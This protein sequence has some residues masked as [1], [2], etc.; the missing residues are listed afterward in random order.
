MSKMRIKKGDTVAVI[1][2]EDSPNKGNFKKGK[3][4]TVFPKKNKVIVEGINM[5][6]KHKKA[7]SASNRV[8]KLIRKRQWMLQRLCLF[9]LV[10][11]NLLV[12]DIR[13]WVTAQNFVFAK[14][15]VNPLRSKGG[16]FSCLD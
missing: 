8:A 7:R 13:Y 10:V 11:E 5:V 9:V 14:S 3:V 1:S 15:A 16:N 2:G 6:T 12:L 4:L